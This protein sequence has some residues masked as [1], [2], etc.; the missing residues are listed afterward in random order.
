MS[1]S[2][3]TPIPAQ[4]FVQRTAVVSMF[5]VEA[6]TLAI[7]KSNSPE[8]KGFAH[9][10]ADEHAV[11][12]SSLRRIV[13]TRSD[14]ALPDRPDGRHLALLSALSNKQGEDFDKAYIEAQREAYR[15][16]TSLMERYAGEG[17]DA[18]LKVFAERSLPVFRELDRKAQALPEAP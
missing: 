7:H 18:E 17:T 15:E 12:T 5:G 1:A 4:D 10:L 11:A 3:Q 13:A 6:A 8:I 9:R 14:I 2:A 16:A